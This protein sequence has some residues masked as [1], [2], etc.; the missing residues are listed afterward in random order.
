MAWLATKR[1]DAGESAVTLGLPLFGLRTGLKAAG[2]RHKTPSWGVAAAIGQS[3]GLAPGVA[4]TVEC[5]GQ[6]GE[7]FVAI[8]P[9]RHRTDTAAVH[10]A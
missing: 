8:S 3:G 6:L 7:G 4:Q 2:V 1:I 9:I 10:D 5:G